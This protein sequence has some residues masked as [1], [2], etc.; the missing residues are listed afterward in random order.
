MFLFF[1][2]LLGKFIF[3]ENKYEKILQKILKIRKNL[4]YFYD[5]KEVNRFLSSE[6]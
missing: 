2:F 4:S 1:Y 3:I 5:I 6:F